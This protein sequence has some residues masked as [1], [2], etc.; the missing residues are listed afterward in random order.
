MGKRGKRGISEK[1]V[2]PPKT[3]SER[4]AEVLSIKSQIE[5]L[6]LGTGNPDVIN[7][8]NELD[9]FRDTGIAWTGSVKLNGHQR[10]IKA[11][12]TT[13]PSVTSSV[14]LVFQKDV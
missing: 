11:I 3:K 1:L 6:G 13:L 2:K 9:I 5:G 14:N 12:L 7:F 10:V 4:E 8:L